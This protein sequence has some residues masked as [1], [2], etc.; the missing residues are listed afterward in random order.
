MNY[1]GTLEDLLDE[2]QDARNLVLNV[3]DIKMG[4]AAVPPPAQ[5]Q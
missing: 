2:K 5:Y 3:L 1:L 4:G